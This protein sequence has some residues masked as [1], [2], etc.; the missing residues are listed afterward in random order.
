ML[1]IRLFGPP[2]VFDEDQPVT[3]KRRGTRALLFYLAAQGKPV[4]RDHL[5]DTFWPDLSVDQAR[6]TLRDSLG[7]IRTDL[8]DRSVLQTRPD[9]VSLDFGKVWV[10]LLELQALFAKII[11][12]VQ[13]LPEDAP[14]PIG[15]YGQMTEAVQLWNGQPFIAN[16]ELSL[17]DE[18]TL[19][20]E[21]VQ[22]PINEMLRRTLRRLAK[23]DEIMGNVSK[24]LEWLW[25]I[26]S[27]DEYDDEINRKIIEAYLHSNLQAEAQEFY[28]ALRSLYETELNIGMPDGILALE[29]RIY[30][31]PVPSSQNAA[32]WT[33]HPSVQV[34]FIGQN[35]MLEQLGLAY[36]TGGGILVFG[37]A[38]AGKT[39]LVQEFV[40][41]QENAL[42]LFVASCHAL[43][44]GMPFAPWINLLRSSV[45]PEHWQK[46]DPIWA[47]PLSLLVPDL[48]KIRPDI[49]HYF[50]EH[51]DV[52]RSIL[53]EAVHQ[54]LLSIAENGPLVLFIDD[55]H[56]A[57]ES[58]LAIVSY[59]LHKSF[60]R[61]GRGLLIM[62][63]RVEESNELL[64]KI[65]LGTYPQ[66]LRHAELRHLNRNEIAEI[67]NYV[68]E[69]GAPETFIDR[70]QQESGGNPFFLLQLLQSL[71]EFGLDLERVEYLPTTQSVQELIQRRLQMLSPGGRELLSIAAV[72]GSHFELSIIEAAI[73][74]SEEQ[75]VDALEE[76]EKARLVRGLE[77]EPLSYGFVHENIREGLL[78]ELN[79]S[80]KRLLNQ[81]AA[82]AL[83][84]QLAGNFAPYAAQLAQYRESAGDFAEA[85]NY[86]VM[87][88]QYAW[89]LASTH[90][91]IE[92]Y[93]HA[94][95]L[96]PRTAGLTSE[97]LYQLYRS[98][99]QVAFE[100][101]DAVLLEDINQGLS[102]LGHTRNSNL[103][104]GLALEGLSDAAMARNQ[105][106]EALKYV[107]EAY[108]YLEHSENIYELIQAEMRQGT[109]LYMLGRIGEAQ[110]WL[111]KVME[112]T[113]H[114]DD[115]M[116]IGLRA[117]NHYHTGLTETIRGYTRRGIE[118]AKLA[119][120]F[121]ARVRS[122]YG[123][124][125]AYS[126]QGLAYWLSASYQLG[127]EACL[128]GLALAD[129]M[130]GWRMYGYIA[131]YAA[132]NET[133]LGLIGDAWDHAQKAIEMGERQGHGEI[134]CLGY[135]SIG[136]IY[137]RLG[138]LEQAARI[139][140]QGAMAA[141]EHYTRFENLYRLGYARFEQHQESGFKVI[142]ETVDLAFKYE[143]GC[144][145]MG[146]MPFLL[147]ALLQ[148]G[149]LAEFEKRAQWFCEQ[150]RERFG[151]D[152]G[153]YT[154]DRI[155]AEKAFKEEGDY[156]TAL[157][158]VGPLVPWY[159]Q[160]GMPWHEVI[161]LHIKQASARHLG[162]AT[163]G[164][165]S[166]MLELLDRMQ[167]SI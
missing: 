42:H 98:W 58:T 20:M 61:A 50:I 141:G 151:T 162:R 1:R 137:L 70:L 21:R 113:D 38:G 90:E 51:S 163:A 18:L 144:M 121:I 14:L 2:L 32:Q 85:F 125:E 91:S 78:V 41:R 149:D 84:A 62:A 35:E 146:G 93:R 86:W 126:V 154:V 39:R 60:F 56:W 3:I 33:V 112:Q 122:T 96:I 107:Q 161:C 82:S 66:P 92:A 29:S 127:L 27:F 49:S 97:H 63:A 157:A 75:V 105:F 45:L 123:E 19:W 72:L 142:Q 48:T 99:N 155:R 76:L 69:R 148:K 30:S 40:R 160:I 95:H 31:P 128:K 77:N 65:M 87:A 46:L 153:H 80:R 23:H 52:P 140:Q 17:S 37:E 54:L 73:H 68:L 165:K 150:V 44:T 94:A 12:A 103:L 109:Y 74:L 130:A 136:D 118:H 81:R 79:P 26:R 59:L 8:P 114:T 134:V 106:A 129:R 117:V 156:E 138:N 13:K 71:Q 143:A 64:G 36:R 47:S 120:K 110:V 4:T 43:E 132:M 116:L 133:D 164:E 9:I 88:G 131:S 104:I 25:L 83:E 101:D 67:S 89:R 53:L 5:T 159:A 22:L 108:P 7:K 10:D 28:E 167:D 15:L 135:R 11:P 16:G 147:S 6:R 166:R 102:T 139:Y 55:V 124:V 152:D 100:I 158:L 145:G 57:D 24:V 119:A 111:Q 115:P 34:P